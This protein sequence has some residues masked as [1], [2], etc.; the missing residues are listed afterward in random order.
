MAVL[1]KKIVPCPIMEAVFELRFEANVPEDAIFGMV[2]DHFRSEYNFEVEQLPI[3]QL[4]KQ[5]RSSD[6]AL[7][8]SPHY[9]MSNET[10]NMQ[11]G[12]RVVT[13]S[14]L[15]E[16]LGWEAF[17]AEIIKTFDNLSEIN[18]F[19]KLNRAALRYINVLRKVDIFEKS[20][21]KVLLDNEPLESGN[22][23]LTTQIVRNSVKSTI[24]VISGAQAK[25]SKEVINGSVVDIDSAIENIGKEDDFV[26]ILN[27]IHDE[28]KRIFYKILGQNYLKEFEATY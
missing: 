15:G 7:M 22:I 4:P 3:L 20:S 6:P 5:V 16:Y 8:F 23:N 24:R 18:I 26:A 2:F 12:P 19:D 11:I 9:K 14:N 1:P 28:E 13:I 25:I 27:N 21:I 17:Q 10:F